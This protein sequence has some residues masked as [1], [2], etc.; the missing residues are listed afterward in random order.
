VI[1]HKGQAFGIWWWDAQWVADAL[2]KAGM[3]TGQ[4]RVVPEP[5]VRAAGDGW[6]VARASTGYE[7][8]LW[9]SNFLVAD[10][11]RRQ[12]FDDQAW[13]DFTRVQPD[14]AGAEA[15]VLMAQE[16]PYTLQSAYRRTQ[17]SDWTPERS[18]QATIAGVGVL[19]IC[20][21][22]WMVGQAVGLNRAAKAAE[23]QTEQLRLRL[24]ASGAVQVQNQVSGLSALRSAVDGA[25]PLVML[26]GAQQAI[27]PFNHALL[28]YT[29][30][31][32]RV[33]IILGRDAADDLAPM[34]RALLASPYFSAVKPQL[35]TKR[36]RLILDL[37]PKG[38]RAT[39][40]KKPV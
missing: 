36:G 7:A 38:L 17:M 15:A 2:E 25:D 10:S 13:S 21:S 14:Q 16:A 30:E 32:D 34:S 8:Q 1:T 6:R 35:D 28:A 5:L 22:V 24:P 39:T 19:L 33:R 29:A 31:R 9:R 37:T 3:D 18:M 20:A 23:T 26:E 4:I 27:K 12:P 11:W 40:V